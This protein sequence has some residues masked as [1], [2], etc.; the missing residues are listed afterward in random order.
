MKTFPDVKSSGAIMYINSTHTNDSS[1]FWSGISTFHKYSN[2][3]VDNGLYAYFEILPATFRV[4]PWV[5]IGKTATELKAVL[6]PMLNELD[7]KKIPYEF[8][9]KDFPTF[10]DL[11]IDMFEDETAGQSALT[12]GWM[13][14]HDDVANRNDQIINALKTVQY[15]RSD[16]FGIIIGHLLN[17]GYGVPVSN[18]AMNPAWRNATDLIITTIP[19]PAGASLAQKADLQNLLTY[20]MDDALRNVSSS[21]CTYVNEVGTQRSAL[22]SYPCFIY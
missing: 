6:Q 3:F 16:L 10:Y 19:V 18:S 7:A 21:G 2:R 15:P 1:V 13:L 17:P 4:R 20:T 5:G 22:F 8:T 14:N 12:G 11:Y 9:I